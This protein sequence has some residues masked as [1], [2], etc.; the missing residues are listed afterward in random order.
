MA[1][2]PGMIILLPGV[3]LVIL[4]CFHPGKDSTLYLLARTLVL[5][6]DFTS[7]HIMLLSKQPST[8]LEN[9]LSTIMEFDTTLPL[10]KQNIL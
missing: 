5:D 8:D 6:M 2:F 1:P 9:A 4:D 3:K 10:T 7:L